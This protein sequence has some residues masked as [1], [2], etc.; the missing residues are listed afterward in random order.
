MALLDAYKSS[1]V[2][3]D[4]FKEKIVAYRDAFE[5]VRE[6]AT[7]NPKALIEEKVL[8]DGDQFMDREVLDEV[9]VLVVGGGADNCGVRGQ[10]QGHR[11]PGLQLLLRGLRTQGLR[12]EG[13]TGVA[14]PQR[15]GQQLQLPQAQD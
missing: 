4:K 11:L 6:A 13:R 8:V 15:H 3:G 10:A 1:I 9:D 7:H 5:E 2:S 12:R 14:E